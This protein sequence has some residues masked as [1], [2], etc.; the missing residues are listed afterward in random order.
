MQQL[1][2]RLA[3]L[4]RFISC[5]T[6]RLKSFFTTL[7]GVKHTNLNKECDLAFGAIKQ[8]LTKPLILA[9]PEASNTLY[10]Y[11]AVSDVSMSAAL[12]K[13]DESWKQ[14][15]MFFI[16]KSLS[17]ME[18]RYT[19]LEQVALALQLAAKKLC[20]YFQAHLIGVLTNLPLQSTI[21]KPNLSGRMA[22]GLLS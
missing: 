15:P 22:N 21:H 6:D 20:L 16:I 7:K 18:T 9:R 10:L 11:L 8:N 14:I 4:G 17:E 3:A 19:P 1:T 2:G 12:F 5:F 13:E